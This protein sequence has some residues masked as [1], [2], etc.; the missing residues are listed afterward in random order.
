[1]NI[2]YKIKIIHRKTIVSKGYEQMHPVHISVIVNESI[3]LAWKSP[4]TQRTIQL[5][6]PHDLIQE[7]Y[8]TLPE[9][10]HYEQKT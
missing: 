2:V 6:G 3:F 9:V 10:F 5:V 8:Q 7:L 1:M 4:E